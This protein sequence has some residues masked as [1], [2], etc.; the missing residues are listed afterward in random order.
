[1]RGKLNKQEIKNY[2]RTMQN[3]EKENNNRNQNEEMAIY[4]VMREIG[5]NK[6]ES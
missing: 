5:N 2:G 3:E 1:M 6:N 4:N